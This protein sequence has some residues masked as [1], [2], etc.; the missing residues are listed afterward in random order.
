MSADEQTGA[1]EQLRENRDKLDRMEPEGR[2]NAQDYAVLDTRTAREKL[3][4]EMK[5]TGY[6]VDRS[7]IGMIQLDECEINNS[8]N[9]KEKDPSAED[10]RRTG[11]IV[12]KD[13]LKRG[14]RIS[15]HGDHKKRG[16]DTITIAAPVELNGKRGNMAVVVMKPKGNRYKVHRILTPEGDTFALPDM[17]NAVL[18]AGVNG[19]SDSVKRRFSLDKPVPELDHAVLRV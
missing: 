11:F 5:R 14:V 13:V 18:M 4:R 2:V 12:L 8:L 6:Q 19:G 10:A 3:V 15:G 1:C 7:D 9:Y 16:Y 17:A